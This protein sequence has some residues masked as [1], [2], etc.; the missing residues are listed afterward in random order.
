MTHK[1]ALVSRSAKFFGIA[2]TAS[3]LREEG[4]RQ[5]K[6]IDAAMRVVHTSLIDAEWD[7]HT[8]TR[9]S[10]QSGARRMIQR[11]PQTSL[12]DAGWDVEAETGGTDVQRDFARPPQT[13][14]LGLGEELD[15][16]ITY[17]ELDGPECLFD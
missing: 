3:G 9:E 11:S 6:A 13:T 14:L 4:G 8:V 7:T 10:H 12:I 2:S 1:A 15:P 16:V 5:A 17:F